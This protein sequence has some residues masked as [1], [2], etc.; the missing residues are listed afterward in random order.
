MAEKPQRKAPP[1]YDP[2]LGSRDETYSIDETYTSSTD[3]RGHSGG[4]LNYHDGKDSKRFSI[5]P[6]VRGFMGRLVNSDRHPWYD[7]DP[8]IQR[9]ALVHR[10]TYWADKEGDVAG[11]VALARWRIGMRAAQMQSEAED[12]TSDIAKLR[13][14]LEYFDKERLWDRLNLLCEETMMDVEGLDEPWRGQTIE[15]INRYY[16]LED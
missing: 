15:L 12:S 14:A 8:A 3:G 7:G 6:A 1:T 11:Q 4:Q 13:D 5:P 16:R 9:D 2:F 10:L